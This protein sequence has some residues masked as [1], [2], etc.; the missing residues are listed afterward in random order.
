M[1]DAP[2]P[3]NSATWDEFMRTTGPAADLRAREGLPPYHYGTHPNLVVDKT[4]PDCGSDAWT[5]VQTLGEI[6]GI[7]GAPAGGSGA[8]Y[9]CGH[10]GAEHVYRERAL[11]D[12]EIVE[13]NALLFRGGLRP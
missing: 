10:C 12:R 6:P 8:Q 5:C 11:T 9:R 7:P 13:R 1:P 2:R 3:D 4:C